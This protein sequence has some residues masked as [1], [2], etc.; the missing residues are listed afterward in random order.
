MMTSSRS[1]PWVLWGRG[2]LSLLASSGEASAWAPAPVRPLAPGSASAVSPPAR[3]RLLG[4]SL[5]GGRLLLSLLGLALLLGRLDQLRLGLADATPSASTASDSSA[6]HDHLVL[7]APAPL[8]DAGA[9]ADLV[10]QVVELRPADVAAGGDLELLDLGRVQRE[11]PLDPDAERLLAD[12]EGLA[13][14]AALALDHDALE[15]LGAAAVALDDLEVHAHAV[16]GGEPGP[17]LEGSLLEASMTVLMRCVMRAGAVAE[18]RLK[19]R[20]CGDSKNARDPL[21][22]RSD[23]KC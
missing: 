16:A 6:R 21:A 20:R 2:T 8:G 12:G 13:R 11:R 22:S 1:A 3:C 10:A 14:A 17:L 15:D 19:R 23:A 5:F 18:R 4:C 9:L 7:D